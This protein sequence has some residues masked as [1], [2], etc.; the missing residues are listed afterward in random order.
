M[1]EPRLSASALTPPFT[2]KALKAK[3]KYLT[4]AKL[5]GILIVEIVKSTIE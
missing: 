1:V 2:E 5:C 3:G 4:K